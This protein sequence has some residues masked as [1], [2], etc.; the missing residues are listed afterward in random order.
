MKPKEYFLIIHVEV[1]LNN[2][3]ILGTTIRG[4]TK[5]QHHRQTFDG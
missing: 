2:R 4:L 5:L 1:G 3:L